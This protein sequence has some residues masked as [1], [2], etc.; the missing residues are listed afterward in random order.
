MQLPHLQM[1]AFS[2]RDPVKPEF[3]ELCTDD[4]RHY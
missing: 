4:T 1:G 3:A 2:F